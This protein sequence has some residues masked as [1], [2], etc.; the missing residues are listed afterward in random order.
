MTIRSSSSEVISPALFFLGEVILANVIYG[1][2]CCDSI[3][4][5]LPLI[6]IHIGFFA[7]EVG[8]SASDTLYLGE[9]VHD[10]L[11]AV[12]VG[13][14]ETKDE[15]EVRLLSGDERWSAVSSCAL[16]ILYSGG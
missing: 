16:F 6:E 1:E 14:E 12:D 8:I 11:L 5:A 15:L 10:F 4:E 9:S 13:V 7:D 2:S 3:W